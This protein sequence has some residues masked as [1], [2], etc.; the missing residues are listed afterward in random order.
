[1]EKKKIN[2]Q[3][4]GFHKPFPHLWVVNWPW[5]GSEAWNSYALGG[6][7][8]PVKWKNATSYSRKNLNA[9]WDDTAKIPRQ[10]G[11]INTSLRVPSSFPILSCKTHAFSHPHVTRTRSPSCLRRHSIEDDD[12]PGQAR[13]LRGCPIE[14]MISLNHWFTLFDL[15]SWLLLDPISFGFGSLRWDCV[16]SWFF[17]F[18]GE[19]WEDLG[20]IDWRGG[21][22]LVSWWQWLIAGA[23]SSSAGR[24]SSSGTWRRTLRRLPVTIDTRRASLWIL[25]LTLSVSYRPSPPSTSWSCFLPSEPSASSPSLTLSSSARN[26][27]ISS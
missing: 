9:V 4:S 11:A 10:N 18:F 20:G 22:D 3:E 19:F 12:G 21:L 26:R 8:I 13:R 16:F 6:T 24:S 14:Y 27:H 5:P 1:M 17:F 7:H 23:W 25:C 15:F 2:F